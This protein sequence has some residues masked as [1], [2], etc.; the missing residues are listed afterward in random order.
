VHVGEADERAQVIAALRADGYEVTD[1]SGDEMAKLHVRYMVGGRAPP[2]LVDERLFRFEFPERPGACID[3]LGAIGVRWNISLFHYRNHGA[4]YGRVLCGLQVP[5]AEL[6]ECR[7]ALDALGYEY[8][9]ETGNPAY[10]L[11]LGAP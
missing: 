6:A 9:D 2:G 1:L 10:R 3:F 5:R 7:R 4:A 8:W 11:F